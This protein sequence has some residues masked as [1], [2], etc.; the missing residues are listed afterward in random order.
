M[1]HIRHFH[2]DVGTAHCHKL[3]Q[4]NEQ[5]LSVHIPCKIQGVQTVALL[6]TGAQISLMNTT[7]YNKLSN[8]TELIDGIQI[9]GIVSGNR[10]EAKLLTDV[11]VLL[12]RKT[13]LIWHFYVAPIKDNVILG[14]DFMCHYGVTLDF[15]AGVMKLKQLYIDLKELV[16]PSGEVLTVSRVLLDQYVDV[17][18]ESV[19]NTTARIENDSLKGTVVLSSKTFNKGITV[20]NMLVHA[21]AQET[22]PIQLVNT[23]K[24]PI[25]LKPGHVVASAM[26]G[27]ILV[28]NVSEINGA[29]VRPDCKEALPEHLT[30]LLERS[31]T[32]LK[33]S[34]QDELEILLKNYQDIFSK[35]SYDLGCF[36]HIQHEIHTGDERPVKQGMRRT[37][38]G[39]EKEEEENLKLMLDL[40]VITESSSDWASAPVLV[41]KKDGSLR[42]CIDFRGLNSKT[43]KDL[44]PLPSISQCLDQLC[45][46]VYFSTLDM[47]SGYWQIEIAEKDRHKTAFITKFGLFEH[48]RMAFG[49]CNA[50][51]TFQR[52]IQFVLRGLTWDKILAYIDDVIVLGKSFEDHLNNLQLT[53]ERFRKYNLKL[54]PK[55]CNLFHTETVFLGRKVSAEGVSVNPE[56][57]EKVQNWPIPK[58]V[59]DVESFLG[60]VNY[61]REHIP[62]YG[63]I[64]GV[65]Y[66]L[67][68]K[69]AVFD[70]TEAHQASFELLKHKL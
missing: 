42:Y 39:F 3:Q 4:S 53:F 5:L 17:P 6:D 40:G 8:K 10:L 43:V 49:L 62:D 45:G 18:A 41:R 12:G 54:K 16:A 57:L 19:L 21:G 15:Q 59:K 27:D 46:N 9:E 14:I 55:K 30:A 11:K 51:A 65:L 24:K 1:K 32:F 20:P 66:Q 64:S 44:F 70:W 23:S 56:N 34:Q 68:G 60:F 50:P 69:K 67:T 26:M 31:K 61:H 33:S 47:A 22:V 7:L 25:T 36:S 13:E 28:Q 35:G 58:S 29:D 2:A 48:K 63:N 52:V 37:P 38:L